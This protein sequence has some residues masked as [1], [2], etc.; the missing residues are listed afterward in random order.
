MGQGKKMPV[1]N[2]GKRR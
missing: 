1:K 2:V